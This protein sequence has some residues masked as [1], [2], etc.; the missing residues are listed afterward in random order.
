MHLYYETD[1]AEGGFSNPRVRKTL[2]DIDESV[3]YVRWR[4]DQAQTVDVRTTE[5]EHPA[6]QQTVRRPPR[7]T[8]FSNGFNDIVITLGT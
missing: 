2:R 1:D 6:A 3:H 4:R 5:A 8:S 7:R